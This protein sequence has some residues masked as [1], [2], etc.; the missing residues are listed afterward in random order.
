VRQTDHLQVQCIIDSIKE[1]YIKDINKEYFGYTNQTI[2]MLLAHLHKNCCK[3]MIKERTDTTEAFYQ[4]WVPLTTYIITF[5]HQLNKH[6]KKCKNINAIISEEAKTLHFIGQMY[7]SDYHTE[8][9][10]TKNEMQMDGN[11]TWLHTLQYFTKRFA[12]CKA[13]GNDCVANSSFDSAAHIN[14]I[15]ANHSIVSTSSDIATPNLYIKSL[16]ESIVAAQE[17]VAKERTPYLGQS[18]SGGPNAQGT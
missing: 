11:K 6:Q 14:N 2:K 3:I 10:M 4:A 17:Y 16:E 18:R 8:E 13:Y 5:G 7:K 15:P 12:Q 9:Q 1:Q